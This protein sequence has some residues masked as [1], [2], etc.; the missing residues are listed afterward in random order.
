MTKPAKGKARQTF[1]GNI[2]AVGTVTVLKWVQH[3]ESIDPARRF[4]L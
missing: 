1:K 3:G 2:S 4:A